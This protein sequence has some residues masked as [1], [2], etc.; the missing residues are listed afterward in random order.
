MGTEKANRHDKKRNSQSNSRPS[1]NRSNSEESYSSQ[2]T[3]KVL[4][5]Y[6]LNKFRQSLSDESEQADQQQQNRADFGNNISGN[7]G[8]SVTQFISARAA[9]V[10]VTPRA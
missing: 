8:K 10:K 7:S 2:D 5:Q 6:Y 3:N 4:F 9:V 1:N